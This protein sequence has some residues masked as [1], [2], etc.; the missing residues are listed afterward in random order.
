MDRL[1]Q[2]IG[3]DHQRDLFAVDDAHRAGVFV[4]VQAVGVGKRF[5]DGSC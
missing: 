4:T 2:Q 3:I 5:G 1:D